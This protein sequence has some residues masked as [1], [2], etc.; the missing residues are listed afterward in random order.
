MTSKVEAPSEKSRVSLGSILISP[1]VIGGFSVVVCLL[2]A[3]FAARYLFNPNS[4]VVQYDQQPGF[5]AVSSAPGSKPLATKSSKSSSSSAKSIKSPA[6]SSSQATQKSD[7]VALASNHFLPTQQFPSERIPW[8]FGAIVFGC[9][10]GCLLLTRSMNQ[11]AK[12]RAIPRS[13]SRRKSG[14]HRS[15]TMHHPLQAT[16]FAIAAGQPDYAPPYPNPA[17]AGVPPAGSLPYRT[18]AHLV[19][20]SRRPSRFTQPVVTVLPSSVVHPL[21]WGEEGLANQ[22]DMRKRQNVS[23]LLNN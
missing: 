23:Q 8:S 4:V 15:K 18:T 5:P 16:G 22:L 17:L 12:S 2:T 3:G 10:G 7:Q 21:D 1:F 13:L 6:R 11:A 20:S 19:N 9:A 14:S